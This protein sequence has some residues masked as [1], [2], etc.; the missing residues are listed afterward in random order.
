MRL[1]CPGYEELDTSGNDLFTSWAKPSER[2]ILVEHMV[3]IVKATAEFREAY[4][5]RDTTSFHLKSTR[6]TLCDSLD[7]SKETQ[8][9][10]LAS[11]TPS[12]ER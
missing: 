6:K 2:E 9:L 1:S 3:D 10:Q 12:G 8:H 7:C 4:D 11:R 5:R